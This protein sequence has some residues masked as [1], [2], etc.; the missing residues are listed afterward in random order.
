MKVGIQIAMSVTVL[1]AINQFIKISLIIGW[2]A[3]ALSQK[4]TENDIIL[5][6]DI[7][8][9]VV[10]GHEL[11]LDIAVPKYLVSPAPVIVDIPGGAW[12]IV[13]KQAEDATFYAKYGFVGAT[14]THRTSDKAIFPAAIHDCKTAIRWLRAHAVKY[15]INPDKIG[16]TGFSSGGHL[17]T[18]LGTSAGD[19]YLEGKGDYL[20]YSSNVQAV[21]DHFGPTDFMQMNDTTGLNL[22]DF[23][24]HLTNESPEAL[25]LGGPVKEKIELARL[26]NP[27]TYIDAKD[28]P[29]LIGH[30]EKDGIVIIK[31]SE[32]LFCKLRNVGVPTEFIRVKNADHMYRPVRWDVD[33]NPSINEINHLTIRWFE[34]WLGKPLIDTNLISERQMSK[35]SDSLKKIPIYYM[36]TIDLPGKVERSYCKG[37]FIILCEGETLVQ[38]VINLEDLSNG[39]NRTFKQDFILSGI[40]LSQKEIMWNF[41]GEI[42]DSELD[43]KFGPMFMQGEKYDNSI[44]GVGFH[45]RIERDSTLDIEK[46][47]YRID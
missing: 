35:T 40:D 37:R 36:L 12:R 41:R 16:V 26:A 8:Y 20:Q 25:F 11:K 18:L 38:G 19:S 10:D 22:V 32:L 23:M 45:I 43:K 44:K 21:V 4:L 31:Q 39:E 17:A 2:T 3:T 24:D 14:I 30:G 42:F 46:Q 5:Y 6:R 9:T 27:I 33:V 34:K 47:V 29:I 1:K 13:N 7:V 15:N 28:P